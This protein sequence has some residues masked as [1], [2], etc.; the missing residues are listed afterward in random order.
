MCPVFCNQGCKHVIVQI[1]LIL[2]L[3]WHGILGGE[4]PYHASAKQ[5]L[6]CINRN[7]PDVLF[8]SW[9][10]AMSD[11]MSSVPVADAWWSMK[12]TRVPITIITQ[13]SLDR[14]GQLQAMV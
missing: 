14:L 7:Q 10:H 6:S 5:L 3:Q 12:E 13:L 11:R 8:N 2:C 4:D 1:I 9:R